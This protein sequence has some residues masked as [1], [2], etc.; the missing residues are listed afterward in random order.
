MDP[1]VTAIGVKFTLQGAETTTLAPQQQFGLAIAQWACS[2]S[3][4]ITVGSYSQIIYW[5]H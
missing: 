3:H 1:D 5:I 4:G 2:E